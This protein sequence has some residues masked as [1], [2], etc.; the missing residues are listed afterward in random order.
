MTLTWRDIPE[1]HSLRAR[2]YRWSGLPKDAGFTKAQII[3][4]YNPVLSELGMSVALRNKATKRDFLICNRCYYNI[5]DYEYRH[6]AQAIDTAFATTT[7]AEEGFM[8]SLARIL[9]ARLENG[10]GLQDAT[11]NHMRT[12][13][14]EAFQDI[15]DSY[16]YVLFM[17][18][19]RKIAPDA[20]DDDL[21]AIFHS[22]S[23]IN[24]KSGEKFRHD[25]VLAFHIARALQ[26]AE[27]LQQQPLPKPATLS[28]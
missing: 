11:I 23:A 12:R 7:V 5:E 6:L 25:P 28:R 15:M 18:G 1:Q 2:G 8:T 4:E 3:Y 14:N 26:D 22:V 20:Q 16:E 21:A 10:I 9:A 17:M 19:D 13:L 27:K 24:F